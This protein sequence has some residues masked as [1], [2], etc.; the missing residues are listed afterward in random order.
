MSVYFDYLMSVVNHLLAAGQ[1]S[2][3]RRWKQFS[4]VQFTCLSTTAS[5]YLL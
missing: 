5:Q 4:V 1:S 2:T 3:A